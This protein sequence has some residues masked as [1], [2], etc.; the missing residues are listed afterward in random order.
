MKNR[1][2]NPFL[3][4]I[5]TTLIIPVSLKFI[6]NWPEKMIGY[7]VDPMDVASLRELFD[8]N[9]WAHLRVW[10]CAKTLPEAQF[11]QVLN[12]SVGSIYEQI[13]H[14]LSIERYWMTAVR[15][16]AQPDGDS[17]PSSDDYP[18]GA[19]LGNLYD[20]TS[21]FLNTILA[22]LSDADLGEMVAYRH[23]SGLSFQNTCGQLAIQVYSHSIDHRAQTLAMLHQFGAPTIGQDFLRYLMDI[24]TQA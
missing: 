2:P 4:S 3:A 22:D 11:R 8:Y 13:F 16:K 18:T 20:E 19:S 21:A 14:T 7:S 10:N 12:Y 9:T 17:F 6:A 5:S 24:Q 15:D 1:S 23:P